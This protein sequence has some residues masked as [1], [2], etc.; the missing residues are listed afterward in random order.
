MNKE[1]TYD[2][3]ISPLMQQVINICREEGIA[4]IAS[5][6]IGHEDGGPN[7]EDATGLT[8]TTHLPDAE[9]QFDPRFNK[10]AAIIRDGAPLRGVGMQITTNHPNGSKTLTAII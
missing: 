6:A 7:G 1:K 8:V 5:F 3:E 10:S 9:G 4:M 2:T